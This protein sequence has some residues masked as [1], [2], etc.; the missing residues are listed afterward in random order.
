M[1]LGACGLTGGLPSTWAGASVRRAQTKRAGERQFPDPPG[2]A[3][4]FSPG[5]GPELQ[6]L[7]LLDSRTYGRLGPAPAFGLGLRYATSSPGSEAFRLV[8]SR[9][10]SFPEC[11]DCRQPTVG[12]LSL[13]NH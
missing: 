9:A 11:L 12:L 8:L 4:S 5:L 13:H 2:A 1:R 6:V 10:T 3:C 7:Q